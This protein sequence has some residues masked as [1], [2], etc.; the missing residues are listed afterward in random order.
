MNTPIRKHRLRVTALLLFALASGCA[1]Q[2]PVRQHP[3]SAG[4]STEQPVP[5]DATAR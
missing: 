5:T 1:S 2:S 3:E 4:D